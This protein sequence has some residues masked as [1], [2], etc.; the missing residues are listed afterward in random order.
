MYVK[1]KTKNEDSLA[2]SRGLDTS[3]FILTSL[4]FLPL[5]QLQLK[6]S[7]G[8]MARRFQEERSSRMAAAKI[9]SQQMRFLEDFH[10]ESAEELLGMLAELQHQLAEE[11]AARQASDRRIMELITAKE[12]LMKQA[13]LEALGDPHA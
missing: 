10:E 9:A 4:P 7:A 6:E 8:S 1:D 13:I 11:R 3:P 12:K 5:S 2:G